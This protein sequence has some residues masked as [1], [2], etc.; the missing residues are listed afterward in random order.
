MYYELLDRRRNV[1]WRFSLDANVIDQERGTN[2]V[3]LINFPYQIHRLA[4]K[5]SQ[6]N[7]LLYIA[8]GTIGATKI[9]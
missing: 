8:T 2:R 3:I 7:S 9:L 5:G 6:V 1:N 4:F